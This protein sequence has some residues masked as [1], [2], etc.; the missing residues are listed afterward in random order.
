MQYCNN[1]KNYAFFQKRYVKMYTT[2]IQLI[3]IDQQ[4]V[5]AKRFGVKL[6]AVGFV[7]ISR[8]LLF[9]IDPVKRS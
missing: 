8:E 5:P 2:S 9:T 4:L 7:D 3:Q 1:T 6:Q